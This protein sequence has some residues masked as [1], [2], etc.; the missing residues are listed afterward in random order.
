VTVCNAFI[1]L[2]RISYDQNPTPFISWGYTG[3]TGYNGSSKGS[4]RN[5]KSYSWGYKGLQKVYRFGQN[6]VT[7]VTPDLGRG[8]TRQA[9]LAKDVTP[10]TPVTPKK[11]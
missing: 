6:S 3:Y 8:V 5:P 10:V 7:S 1:G 11:Q 2:I 4:T 9:A